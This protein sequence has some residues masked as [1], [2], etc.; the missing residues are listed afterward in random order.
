MY[1]NKIITHLL[2][3]L[4]FIL[5]FQTRY[6]YKYGYLNGGVWEYGTFSIYGTQIL[7]WLIIILF[8]IYKFRKKEFWQ[9]VLSKRHFQTSW[10][11]LI[12]IILFLSFNF[13]NIFLS[14]NFDISYQH[15]FW[16]L[17]SM[18]LGI[19][20]I[21][22]DNTPL[23]PLK[24][25][26]RTNLLLMFWL[27]GV[28]QGGL[29]IYQ[30]AVQKVFAC[31]WLG[32]ASQNPADGGV[33]VIAFGD[34]R[35]LRAYGSFGW[36]NMLG[37]F[38][39]VC[40]LIGLIIIIKNQSEPR[41]KMCCVSLTLGH[42]LRSFIT[43]PTSLKD[44]FV[45]GEKLSLFKKTLFTLGQLVILIG[46]ILSFSRGAWLALIVGII[47]LLFILKYKAVLSSRGA[48]SVIPT[49]LARVEGSLRWFFKDN[50]CRRDSSSC[51]GLGMTNVADY[52]HENKRLYV[53][54]KQLFYYLILT[55][56]LIISFAP[57]F[58]ARFNLDNKV[59]SR[60]YSE[61][62]QEYYQA[63][64]VISIDW[65]K[66]MFIGIGQG[67]YTLSRYWQDPNLDSWV[68][69][70]AHNIY[71]LWLAET[72]IVGLLIYLFTYLFII[73]YVWKYNPLFIPVLLVM[74]IHGAFDHWWWTLHSGI[75]F[76]WV[77]LALG[78]KNKSFKQ[79]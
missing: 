19:V 63:G 77:I 55:L 41:T 35:Y 69:Q 54:F 30:F 16:I 68:Y 3:L 49:E 66:E 33:S 11:R 61:H 32:M 2:Y 23:T 56:V 6:I 74:L 25:G 40:L 75:V 1:L 62:K 76:W 52:Q 67:T 42:R 39:A 64:S 58:N 44:L 79:N 50:L 9:A 26:V 27:S 71:V 65:D 37:S 17:G 24:G 8:A 46:L 7:L 38:L 45:R 28:V 57:L 72:G 59:E 15:W 22:N 5:P 12:F 73:G 21:S 60:S 20:I 4:V 18:C 70:P 53:L 47:V 31:K 13:V 34:E 51:E 48:S 36:P 78:L 43:H 14:I 29:A 10:P